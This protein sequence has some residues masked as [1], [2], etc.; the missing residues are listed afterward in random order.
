VFGED[1]RHVVSMP[2]EPH[3]IV[4]QLVRQPAARRKVG[5]L[6]HERQSPGQVADAGQRAD[7]LGL[8]L[9]WREAR[10][11]HDR[12][13]AVWLESMSQLRSYIA[14][15]VGY[16]PDPFGGDDACP[17]RT[18]PFALGEA[19]HGIADAATDELSDQ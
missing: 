16:H 2:E 5:A 3:P 9:G 6:S 15:P 19:D 10:H 12:Q 14:N 4:E 13:V 1:C 8:P 11:H 7:Q 17:Q 18:R